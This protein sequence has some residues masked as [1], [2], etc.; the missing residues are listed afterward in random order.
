MGASKKSRSLSKK[1][2]LLFE[3]VLRVSIQIVWIALG[4]KALNQIGEYNVL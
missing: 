3:S 4:R 1:E 2:S